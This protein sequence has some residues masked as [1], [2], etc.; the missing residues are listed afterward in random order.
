MRVPRELCHLTPDGDWAAGPGTGECV[1]VWPYTQHWAHP[2][3]TRDPRRTDPVNVFVIGALPADVTGDLSPS[4]WSRPDDGETHRLWI[5]GHLRRMEDH[6]TWGTREDRFHARLWAVGGGTMIAVHEEYLGNGNRHVVVSWNAARDRLYA[7]LT[8]AGYA[9]LSPSGIV[10][11]E[12]LR[13]VPGDG[14]IW[15]AVAG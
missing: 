8:G 12:N 6:V 9:R 1:R 2:Y 4:G 15:R 5:D 13:G 3:R 11:V 14:R 10:A 7:D